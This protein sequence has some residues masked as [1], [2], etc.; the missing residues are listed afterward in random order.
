MFQLW[1]V[2]LAAGALLTY[3]LWK[4]TV[5][6]SGFPPGPPW[7]PLVGNVFLVQK[8][9][10]KFGGQH[11]V[12]E[13]L[14]KKHHTKLVGMRLGREK[15]V[16]VLGYSLVKEALT[17]DNLCGRPDN[18]FTRMRTSGKRMGVTFTD[19]AYWEEHRCFIVRTLKEVGYGRN[20]MN[21]LIKRE[22]EEVIQIIDDLEGPVTSGQLFPIS[23]LN[24]LWT[25]AT[26]KRIERD[27]NML[28]ELIDILKKR[29]KLF[30]MS[31]G[32]LNHIPWL[33][34]IAPV[35]SGYSLLV[36]VNHKLIS[37]FAETIKAHLTS[38]NQ[39]CSSDDL[40]YAYIREIKNRSND[41]KTT[42]TETQMVMTIL[43]LF[44]AGAQ[45]TSITIDLALMMMIIYPAIQT[46]VHA[47]LDA[48]KGPICWTN[49]TNFPYVEAVIFEVQRF[50]HTAAISGPR[51]A[52]QDCELD[53][54]NIPRDTTVLIDLK[55]VH[56]DEE[57]WTDPKTFRPERFL[58]E[59]GQ[60]VNT[61]R[62][63][64]FSLGKRKC[65][66]DGLARACLFEYFSG[67]LLRYEITCPEGERLPS[68]QLIPGI[69]YL[70]KP[71][72]AIFRRRVM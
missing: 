70:P 64:P 69:I 45:T 36:K 67:L 71:Y 3:F 68:M 19:G 66:G 14:S 43:D 56:M 34:F 42:F 12:F 9:G 23:V 29:S 6:P 18:F 41:P 63:I 39:L 62:L 32:L 28:K 65:L 46:K 37:F 30:D 49:R 24:V 47:E 53:G 5:R 58:N 61:E 16:A 51:R 44:I 38:Y 17:N 10:R 27:D 33:R 72:K 13:Y 4:D 60:L 2:F 8:L 21:E 54:Y 31:G 1:F 22:L 15:V 26:G 11:G 59:D 57:Y 52:M 48:F 50:F 40:I 7:V 35:W 20:S 55:S 25:L